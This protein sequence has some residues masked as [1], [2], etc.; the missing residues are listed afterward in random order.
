MLILPG[1][2][3]LSAFRVQRLLAQLKAIDPAITGIT[4]RFVHFIESGV[5]LSDDDHERL[6][7]L[8]TYGEPFEGSPEGEQFVVIPRFG[9]ISPWASKATD[10]TRNC[11][12]AQIHRIERGVIYGLQMTSGQ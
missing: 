10:I 6:A 9:T 7:A 5:A 8:L 4:G 12:M 1:S 2:S 11:G 3:A